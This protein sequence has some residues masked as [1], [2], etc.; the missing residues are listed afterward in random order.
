PAVWRRTVSCASESA[1]RACSVS[2]STRTWT[3]ETVARAASA[4]EVLPDAQGEVPLSLWRVELGDLR[5]RA[6]I[7]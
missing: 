3:I 4:V 7:G 1:A 2:A 5:D 6:A